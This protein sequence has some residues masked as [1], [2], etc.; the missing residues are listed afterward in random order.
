ML[1]IKGINIITEKLII[2]MGWSVQYE[3]KD[4]KKMQ[5]LF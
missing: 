2:S 5:V 3:H 4:F 1:K